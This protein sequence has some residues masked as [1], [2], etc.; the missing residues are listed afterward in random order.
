MEAINYFSSLVISFFGIYIGLALAYIAPEELNPGVKYLKI[1]QNILFAITIFVFAHYSKLNLV[2]NAA[3]AIIVL[4]ILFKTKISSRAL[5][6]FLGVL[7]FL[8]IK[9]IQLFLIEST[10]IFL[11]GFPSG[12]LFVRKHIKTEKLSVIRK[13][14][15]NYYPFLLLSGILYLIKIAQQF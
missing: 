8:S 1:F 15:L 4:L 7:F 12:T 2:L 5:Y 11:F 6:L 14:F 13:L 9:D 3:I 10:L